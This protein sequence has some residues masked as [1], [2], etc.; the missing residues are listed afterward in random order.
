MLDGANCTLNNTSTTGAIVQTHV[1][2][3]ANCT[4]ANSCTTGAI[5]LE[6]LLTGN[7]CTLNNTSSTGAISGAT[8]AYKSSGGPP[9]RKHFDPIF[10]FGKQNK[11]LD[12]VLIKHDDL[13]KTS[14]LK[15]IAAKP[16]VAAVQLIANN[17][18]LRNICTAG[19][20][21]TYIRLNSG[22]MVSESF[23]RRNRVGIIRTNSVNH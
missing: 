1:L 20:I 12:S 3:G 18:I 16:R 22:L 11:P 14:R 17:C 9:K 13:V 19:T 10:N 23:I 5:S 8:E 15:N 4:Q 21:S 7:N 6:V 2:T